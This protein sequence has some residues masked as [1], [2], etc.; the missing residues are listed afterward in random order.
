ME[1]KITLK[2]MIHAPRELVFKYWTD[3]VLIEKWASARD[4]TLRIP[5]FDARSGGSYRYEHSRQGQMIICEGRFLEY[6][7]ENKLTIADHVITPDGK[8]IFDRLETSVTFMDDMNGTKLIINQSGFPDEDSRNDCEDAME[9][10]MNK[11]QE[12]VE[13]MRFQPGQELRRHQVR[14]I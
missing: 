5:H 8:T 1:H 10:V 13:Y 9:E 3:P 6:I 14:G 2:K 4:M 7:P 12:L 11:L